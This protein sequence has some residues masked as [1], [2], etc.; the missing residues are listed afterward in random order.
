MGRFDHCAVG[1][2]DRDGIGRWVDVFE[3]GTPYVEIVSW[4]VVACASCVSSN[5][6]GDRFACLCG[7]SMCTCMGRRLYL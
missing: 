1:Q 4:E 6:A 5:G 3:Y 7:I 2:G